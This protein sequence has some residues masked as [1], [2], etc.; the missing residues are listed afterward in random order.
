MQFLVFGAH[1]FFLLFRHCCRVAWIAA[2]LQAVL[3]FVC[4]LLLVL[5]F[6]LECGRFPFLKA[7]EFLRHFCCQ[8]YAVDLQ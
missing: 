4:S 2:I 8:T 5:A 1:P 3:L 7:G 6:Q